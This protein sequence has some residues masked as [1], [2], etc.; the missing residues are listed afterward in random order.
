MVI[1]NPDPHLCEPEQDGPVQLHHCLV[2]PV[3]VASAN[4]KAEGIGTP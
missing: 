1:H 4:V 3:R 2:P